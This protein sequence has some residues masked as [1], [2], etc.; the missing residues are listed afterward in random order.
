MV[1]VLIAAASVCDAAPISI[2]PPGLQQTLV[3]RTIGSTLSKELPLKLDAGAAWPT[4]DVLPGGPFIGKPFHVTAST[5]QQPLAPG[6]YLIPV[7]AYCTQYSVHRPGGGVAYKL[8][9]IQ[10]HAANALSA[11]VLRGAMKAVP[12]SELQAVQWSIQ[13]GITYAQM[14]S[15]YQRTVDALIPEYKSELNEDFVQKVQDTYSRV[16]GANAAI[17]PLE[18]LLAKMGTPG[19]LLL[20]AKRQREVILGSYKNDQIRN[21]RLFDGQAN[22]AR[23]VPAESGPWTVVIPGVAYERFKVIEGWQGRN[24]LEVRVV[25][26][27]RQRT[28]HRRYG[29]VAFQ[30]RASD[31]SLLQLFGA[32]LAN[33][34]KRAVNDV[35]ETVDI[36]TSVVGGVIGYSIG[37]P[38]QALIA[39]PTIE[40]PGPPCNDRRIQW[41]FSPDVTGYHRYEY[42][43]K[44]CAKSSPWCTVEAVYRIMLSDTEYIAPAKVFRHQP[45]VN[46][47]R[48]DLADVVSPN[49]IV[50]GVDD[51]THSVTNYTLPGHLFYPGTVRRR[52]FDD[53]SFVYVDTFG[54]GTGSE[55][56]TNLAMA[57]GLWPAIDRLLSSRV[58]RG[59]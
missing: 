20:S 34:A 45:V 46:C 44:I 16:A 57:R 31:V 24:V 56:F 53:D 5:L 11:L 55:R 48:Y 30:A 12:Y 51:W 22:V 19:E 59:H 3:V 33:S 35:S 4:V 49:P 1:L 36:A 23:A 9:P 15:S 41:S 47:A 25:S 54:E 42:Q 40:A 13:G 32:A 27:T 28:S 18:T 52:V 21:Q 37:E 43:T 58:A 7:T 17:P 6:D 50:V 39:V 29:V 10:G 2:V 38:T 14:P 8:A 26:Q